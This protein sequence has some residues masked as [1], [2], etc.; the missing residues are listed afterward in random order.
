MDGTAELKDSSVATQDSSKGKER[1]P[2]KTPET[3]AREKAVSDAL[4]AAGRT[5]KA[6]EERATALEAREQT[7]KA[8]EAKAEERQKQK[9]AEELEKAGEE[10]RPL[11]QR[12][13]QLRIDQIA[14]KQ[15]EEEHE[16]KVAQHQAEIDE[17]RATK[18]EVAVF[19]IATKHGADADWLKGLGISDLDKL[20]TIAKGA[21]TQK[22]ADAD[23]GKTMG[24]GGIPESAKG[25]IRSGWDKI[26]SK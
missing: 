7:I 23:N 15:K 21:S 13:Q 3:L 10:E 9:D 12:K 1:T 2:E 19:N 24:G 20:D 18:F 22:L 6:L 11:I 8:N 5:A 14:F 4:S 16:R 26:H 25:K 17:V